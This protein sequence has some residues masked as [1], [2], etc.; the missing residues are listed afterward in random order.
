MSN[1]TATRILASE[2]LD[3]LTRIEW[4]GDVILHMH[5][6]CPACE[7]HRNT[8]HKPD[9]DLARVRDLCREAMERKGS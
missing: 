7:N 1:S 3:L 9:C 6:L 8:S 5:P 4:S 2:T